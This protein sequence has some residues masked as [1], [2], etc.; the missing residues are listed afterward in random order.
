MPC[1]EGVSPRL[2]N[3]GSPGL[4]VDGNDDLYLIMGSGVCIKGRGVEAIYP[5]ILQDEHKICDGN[6]RSK[7]R[8]GRVVDLVW[9]ADLGSPLIDSRPIAA[10]FGPKH[11][12]GN[13]ALWIVDLAAAALRMVCDKL[14]VTVVGLTGKPYRD[15]YSRLGK[16][17][18]EEQYATLI[19]P[20]QCLRISHTP[21]VII[22]ER[23]T[24]TSSRVRILDMST[25]KVSTLAT[26]PN[27]LPLVLRAYKHHDC[28]HSEYAHPIRSTIF[29]H[30]QDGTSSLNLL[31]GQVEYLSRGG[32]LSSGNKDLVPIVSRCAVYAKPGPQCAGVSRILCGQDGRQLVLLEKEGEYAYL[33]SLKEIILANDRGVWIASSELPWADKFRLYKHARANF[34]ELDLSVYINNDEVSG[35]LLLVHASSGRT[36]RIHEHILTSLWKVA[37]EALVLAVKKSMLPDDVIDKF[38]RLLHHEPLLENL[39]TR[40]KLDLALKLLHIGC[41]SGLKSNDLLPW[42]SSF[43]RC[44]RPVTLFRALIKTWNDESTPWTTAD[45]PI[46]AIAL[47]LGVQNFEVTEA[48]NALRRLEADRS[49]QEVMSHV[50]KHSICCEH[51]FC[52]RVGYRGLERSN[53]L[54]FPLDG[55]LSVL[56]AF[57]QLAL[58]RASL[59]PGS[60]ASAVGNESSSGAL[61]S[62]ASFFQGDVLFVL[63]EVSLAAVAKLIHLHLNWLWFRRL[64]AVKTC[65]EAT[66]LIVY[67]PSWV[68]PNI[69]TAV[70]DSLM[71][72]FHTELTAK[73][74]CEVLALGGELDLFD[75]DG[76]PYP[77]FELLHRYC[78]A[79]LQRISREAEAA[80]E[81]A[82]RRELSFPS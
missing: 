55:G 5:F 81:R 59:N 47:E 71:S 2:G 33:A 58:D 56:E 61:K 50:L 18:N 45:D 63:P 10:A 7:A 42:F 62:A 8:T 26:N 35:D 15:G 39:E 12:L 22:F 64:M 75:L 20:A 28:T 31:T 27:P 4:A 24:D 78:T 74:A 70:L 25:W 82:W 34:H 13:G 9:D 6:I 49:T 37:P 36:W 14:L 41:Q 3:F 29:T 44:T 16:V 1:A 77:P 32:P 21:N 51:P 60:S 17:D 79:L 80:A 66:T 73:E 48:T 69:C 53:A 76:V 23:P 67:M 65:D 54:W 38:I 30:T 57:Y 43:L 40:E 46:V 19:R 72:E 52:E 68:T 11:R